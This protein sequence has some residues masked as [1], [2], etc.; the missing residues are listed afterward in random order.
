MNET[1]KETDDKKVIGRIRDS[2]VSEFWGAPVRFVVTATSGLT[3]VFGSIAWAFGVSTTG[4]TLQ[5]VPLVAKL[6]LII[7]AFSSM[8]LTV[9]NVQNFFGA[10]SNQGGDQGRMAIAAFLI[11]ILFGWAAISLQALFAES[12]MV[13]RSE[14]ATVFTFLGI[15][16]LVWMVYFCRIYFLK[17]EREKLRSMGIYTSGYTSPPVRRFMYFC[18]LSNAFWFFVFLVVEGIQIG[19]GVTRSDFP[20]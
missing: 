11:S 16:P 13:N 1:S 10:R 9:A 2:I 18:M 7:F 15:F 12:L 6:L 17:R 8:S 20:N 19:G 3:I 14:K 5:S 4:L